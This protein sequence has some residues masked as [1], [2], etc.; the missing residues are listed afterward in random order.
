MERRCYYCKE[1]YTLGVHQIYCSEECFK[2]ARTKTCPC[3]KQSYVPGRPSR[4]KAFCDDCTRR[5]RDIV[6]QTVFQQTRERQMAQAEVRVVCNYAKC[7]R[8]YDLIPLTRNQAKRPSECRHPECKV[9]YRD[10]CHGGKRLPTSREIF[11]KSCGKSRGY[12]PPSYAREYEYCLKCSRRQHPTKNRIPASDKEWRPCSLP[13]CN[14]GRY[15][16]ISTIKRYPERKFVCSRAHSRASAPAPRIHCRSC[17]RERRLRSSHIP[18]TF[19]AQTMTFVCRVCQ[20]SKTVVETFTCD[21]VG[22][23]KTFERRVSRKALKKPH[24]CSPECQGEY[25]RLLQRLCARCG[26]RIQRRGLNNTYCSWDCFQEAK[27][28]RPNPHRQ[29]SK[30]E[31]TV[32]EAIARGIRG[33][34]TIEREYGVARNTVRRVFREQG[35]VA[36]PH[37][38]L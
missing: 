11:C 34:R 13:G 17:P 38:T 32:L 9:A 19:D 10:D 31:R 14:S 20:P 4:K 6:A 3:G 5:R 24:F 7:P 22:C 26:Q 2:A 15:V 28:G 30:A 21:G 33:A 18:R 12:H 23:D 25:R 16:P 37:V 27:T 29:P 35:I 1:P 36:G 8:P